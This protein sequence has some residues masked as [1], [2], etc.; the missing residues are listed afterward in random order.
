MKES[1]TYIAVPPGE[2]IKEQLEERG[3]TEEE[4]SIRMGMQQG[5]TRRLL[6]GEERLT[7]EMATKLEAVLGIPKEFWNKLECIYQEKRV[8]V[9]QENSNLK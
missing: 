6:E 8:K 5:Q 9:E 2:T 7:H 1:K 3:I 4:F